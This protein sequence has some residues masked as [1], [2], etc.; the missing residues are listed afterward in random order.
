[1][2]IKSIKSLKFGSTVLVLVFLI[3]LNFS[4]SQNAVYFDLTED[5]IY[6]ISDASRN[7]LKNLEKEV[8]VNFYISKDLPV[9]MQALKTQLV[10]D[11]N[12]YQDIAGSKLKV[13]YIEPENTPEKIQ[14]LEAKGIPQLQFNVVQ[15][16]KYE[17][18]QGFFGVE[19]VSGESGNEKRELIPMV[20]SIDNWEYDFVSAVYSVS[21]EKKE[22]V[23]FLSGHGEKEVDLSELK[24]S[25]DAV[26]VKIEP[27]GD[28]KGFYVEKQTTTKD[29]KGEDKSVTEKVPV[30][31]IT[32]AIINPSSK[33]TDEEIAV[34]DEYMKNGGNVIVMSGAVNVDVSQGISAE[35][36]PDN[37]LNGFMKKYG[38]EV[39][40]D[41]IY[42]VSNSN[43]SYQRGFFTMSTPYP[44][45]VK[46]IGENFANNPALSGIQSVIFPWASSL[47]L[48]DSN[49]YFATP[50]I[51]STQKASSISGSFDI[52]PDRNFPFD[53]VS[54]K[55]IMAVARPKDSNSKSGELL[56]IGDPYFVL[57]NFSKQVSDNQTFFLNLID[58][59]S[60]TVNLSSIRAK[61]IADRPVKELNEGEK[62][63]WKFIA[64]LSGALVLDTYG[65]YRIVRRK[66]HMGKA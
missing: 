47:A 49:D 16:D 65:L 57:L 52:M 4:V 48:S 37:G 34:L 12:Q 35:L 54:K 26:D 64:I 38:I 39:N 13:S 18:K 55:T 32:L 21:K 10:D 53:N 60:N 44:F 28:K 3:A 33:I 56:A 36:I 43:I 59:V 50:V 29:E 22:T 42:D 66:K 31:P 40:S 14:E 58:S 20:Q 27:S 6:T 7:I 9:N 11:M 8:D 15:K 19:I 51:S 45:F 61:N 5:K 24:K 46:A 17:V 30:Q 41:M 23:A 62:N 25:Y 63:Y 2:N 1:M